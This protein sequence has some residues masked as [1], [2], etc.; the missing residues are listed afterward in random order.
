LKFSAKEKKAIFGWAWVL[1]LVLVLSV[2]FFS[3]DE[4]F[5]GIVGLKSHEVTVARAARI[6]RLHVLP[7]QEVRVG[8]LLLELEDHQLELDYQ[9]T[10]TEY[11]GLREQRNLVR[12][13]LREDTAVTARLQGLGEELRLLEQERE[14]LLVFSHLKGRVE[15]VFRRQGE[16]TSA[17]LPILSI[18]EE[19]PNLVRG[20]VHESVIAELKVGGRVRVSGAQGQ[21]SGADGVILSFGTSIVPFPERLLKDPARPVW[22]REVLVEVKDAHQFILGEKVTIQRALGE[23]QWFSIARASAPKA[24]IEKDLRELRQHEISAKLGRKFEVSGI[25]Y[26]PSVRRYLLVSDGTHK[27]KKTQFAWLDPQSGDVQEALVS[28]ADGVAD[29]ESLALDARGRV[30]ALSSLTKRHKKKVRR[31]VLLVL[32]L[33]G[34]RLKLVQELDFHALLARAL[35]PDESKALADFDVE[36]LTVKGDRLYFGLRAPLDAQQ[37]ALI[38]QVSSL[39][40]LLAK[41]DLSVTPF[42]RVPLALAGVKLGIAA[43]E[44][45]GEVIYLAAAPADKASRQ[46]AI[47]RLDAQGKA[48]LV[49]AF[50][51]KKPEGIACGPEGRELVVGLDHGAGPSKALVYGR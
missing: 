43:L 40:A 39:E 10:K 45:C 3:H 27:T 44:T 22:G 30:L 16:L 47:Y 29:I 36:G 11:E 18:L 1:A 21:R 25:V 49:L 24:A 34:L 38:Y 7:G 26:L 28:G 31:D 19:R 37:S 6:K 5:V 2:Q 8:E 32:E 14:K 50:A 4:N 12:E 23:R 13:L 15:A 33:D 48:E 17:H 46:G 51:D 35:G 41:T 20:Y 42:L 9:R